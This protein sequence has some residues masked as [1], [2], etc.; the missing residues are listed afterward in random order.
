MSLARR[1]ECKFIGSTSTL[2]QAFSNIYFAISGMYSIEDVSSSY[3][4]ADL[5]RW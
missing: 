2:T 3:T 1:E 4:Q 5:N